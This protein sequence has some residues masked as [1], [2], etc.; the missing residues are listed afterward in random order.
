MD[1]PIA[2]SAPAAI[3]IININAWLSKSSKYSENTAKL[4]MHESIIIS[5]DII[6]NSMFRRLKNTPIMPK[7]NKYIG[8][9]ICIHIYIKYL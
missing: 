1:N 6:V 9:M 3:I 5:K 2:V 7:I 4:K 8:N